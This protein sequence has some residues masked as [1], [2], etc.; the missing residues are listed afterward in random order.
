MS[1][2][3]TG[4]SATGTTA[5]TA[6]PLTAKYN[7]ISTVGIFDNGVVVTQD[8]FT[9]KE[10]SIRNTALLSLNVY[11]SPDGTINGGGT[12][13]PVAILTG[14]TLRFITNDGTNWFSFN[15]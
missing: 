12:N 5:E 6:Y 8:S 3:Q 13:V 11:P 1:C 15:G 2:I 7:T 10:V 4:I 9:C 14:T